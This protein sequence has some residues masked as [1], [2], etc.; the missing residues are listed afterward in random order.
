MKRLKPYHHIVFSIIFLAELLIIISNKQQFEYVVKPTILIWIIS[1]FLQITPAQ[2]KFYLWGL[3]AFLFSLIGD[4]ILLFSSLNEVFF[5]AGI[6]SFL[7][8]HIFFIITFNQHPHQKP[9]YLKLKPIWI[10][11]VVIVG[12]TL[13][14]RLFSHLDPVLKFA[15]FIYA[16][17]ISTMLL[18]ALNRKNQVAP[19]SFFWVMLGAAL[20]FISD[21]LLAINR[22]WLPVPLSGVWIMST[23]ML[24]QYFILIG[25]VN[26]EQ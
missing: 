18:L 21:S 23:Y 10:M 2:S 16:A 4:V 20:F 8:S 25:L 12:L 6:G 3:I 11:A 5:L 24:A 1:I 15:V 9:A 26:Q 14:A 13:Y 7:L 17:A 19:N 22:F